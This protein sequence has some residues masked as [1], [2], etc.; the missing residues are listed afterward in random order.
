VIKEVRD[1][2]DV[3]DAAIEELEDSDYI[4]TPLLVESLQ[5]ANELVREKLVL[6]GVDE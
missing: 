6:A 3:V 5:N 4:A 1:L 2:V